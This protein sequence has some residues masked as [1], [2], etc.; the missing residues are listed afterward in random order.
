[1]VARDHPAKRKC[2]FFG[3]KEANPLISKDECRFVW[4]KAI[5]D[6]PVLNVNIFELDLWKP[7][8]NKTKTVGYWIGKGAF[9]P[10]LVPPGAIEVNRDNFRDRTELARFM[11]SCDYFISFDPMT[12]I[13]TEATFAGTP[14]L[15]HN[16]GHSSDQPGWT[17]EEVKSVGWN[18]YGIAYSPEEMDFARKTVHLA[19]GHYKEIM[20]TFPKTIDN[21][22]KITQER[23]A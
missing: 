7:Y 13:V 1:M 5:S 19:K 22:I 9:D 21:F 18:K 6:D 10:S 2:Y 14:V 12:A 3:N 4:L 16:I 8:G 23:F 17:N 20:K 11:S 15:I